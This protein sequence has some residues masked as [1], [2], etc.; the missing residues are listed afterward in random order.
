M[1]KRANRI[2]G[3][4][5]VYMRPGS[6]Y[7][8]ITYWNGWHQE[9]ESAHTTDYAEAVKTLQRK[10]GEVAVGKSAGAERIRIAALLQ[11]VVDD[12]RLHDPCRSSGSRAA[13]QQTSQTGVRPTPSR[14]LQYK[15]TESIHRA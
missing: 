12:Y 4:G 10:L 6:P 2:K 7:W 5:N 15:G 8:Q 1:S 9:R 11:L 3:Q 14:C 13:H